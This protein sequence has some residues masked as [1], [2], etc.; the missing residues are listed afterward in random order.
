VGGYGI[1]HT[2][3]C[4]YMATEEAFPDVLPIPP[5]L[6]VI[7]EGWPILSNQRPVWVIPLKPI[8]DAVHEGVS[9]GS[10]GIS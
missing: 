3:S 9:C 2:Y 5:S 8:D 4:K 7:E 6:F 1:N 10:G